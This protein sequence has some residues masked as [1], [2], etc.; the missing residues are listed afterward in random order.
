[1][2]SP[3]LPPIP[4]QQINNPSSEIEGIANRVIESLKQQPPTARPD[5]PDDFWSSPSV[6][7][8]EVYG[9]GQ[10]VMSQTDEW[11][12][13]TI[14]R[15]PV[16]DQSGQQIG[17]WA[18]R[19]HYLPLYFPQHSSQ[20]MRFNRNGNPNNTDQAVWFEEEL[21][22]RDQPSKK[23]KVY[24]DQASGKVSA[25]E[26][27]SGDR[28]EGLNY[29]YNKEGEIENIEY[30][31]LDPITRTPLTRKEIYKKEPPVRAVSPTI[32]PAD[33]QPAAPIT[34]ASKQGFLRRLFRR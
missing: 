22:L 33:S 1:M 21:S 11:G 8:G 12:S 6:F 18:K 3:D 14:Y 24:L 27:K 15:R 28:I 5:T 23:V 16:L 26:M 2:I 29:K 10:Q 7:N 17:E 34:V 30:V 19:G 13:T 31:Q 20:Y 32:Q 4:D 9:P 25:V